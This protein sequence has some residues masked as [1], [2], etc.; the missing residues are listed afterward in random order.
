[1]ISGWTE[2]MD[3]ETGE[4]YEFR[5]GDLYAI[6]PDTAYAQRVKVGTNILFLNCRVVGENYE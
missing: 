6:L 3:V 1:M 5:T 4:I 2:Y